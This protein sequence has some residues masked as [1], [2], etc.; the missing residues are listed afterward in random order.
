[1]DS[2]HVSL[3]RATQPSLTC[4]QHTQQIKGDVSQRRLP[5]TMLGRCSGLP[6]GRAAGSMS[7][8]L[9]DVEGPVSPQDKTEL[10]R[11]ARALMWSE[12]PKLQHSPGEPLHSPAHHAHN[13]HRA[14]IPSSQKVPQRDKGKVQI[15]IGHKS[16]NKLLLLGPVQSGAL[17]MPGPETALCEAHPPP[18]APLAFLTCVPSSP[19][20]PC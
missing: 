8:T 2:K 18:M 6:L 16:Q 1:M 7:H 4:R 11:I 3:D 19:A 20:G 10:G 15:T 5:N 13:L 9:P 17:Q 12:G 14:T